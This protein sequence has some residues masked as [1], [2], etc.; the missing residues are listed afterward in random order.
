MSAPPLETIPQ[1]S[2]VSGPQDGRSVVEGLACLLRSAALR[3]RYAIDPNGV[4]AALG[5]CIS[6]RPA[7]S[8]LTPKDLDFQARI[9][10]RKRFTEVKELLPQT[11]ALL[12]EQ[13]WTVFQVYA[14][15][16]WPTDAGGA[17][18]DALSFHAAV[19]AQFPKQACNTERNR[20]S[21]QQSTKRC[22]I[23]W[24]RDASLNRRCPY[25]LQVLFRFT[26]RDC[27]DWTLHLGL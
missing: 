3:E 20:L 2:T 25:G 24:V 12:G 5:I 11:C 15:E 17:A 7:F 16:Q 4:L 9:L 23:H 13:A 18:E 14:R 26:A 1:V 21:F 8:A 22:R 10:L 19:A 6:D 27:R